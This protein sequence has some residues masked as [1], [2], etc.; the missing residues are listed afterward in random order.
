MQA[1]LPSSSLGNPALA[2]LDRY[3][4]VCTPRLDTM[5]A[6]ANDEWQSYLKD[7]HNRAQ[8]EHQQ[9]LADSSSNDPQLQANW[10]RSMKDAFREMD[11]VFNLTYAPIG[12]H[13]L[14][15]G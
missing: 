9:R 12:F 6:V 7:P 15:V 10:F 8:R 4:K 2:K 13:F 5:C 14:D 3:R 1:T 11:E